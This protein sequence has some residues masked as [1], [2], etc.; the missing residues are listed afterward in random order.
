MKTAGSLGTK[1]IDSEAHTH[2]HKD[3]ERG[4]RQRERAGGGR[5]RER[6]REG[7]GRERD[8]LCA[9]FLYHLSF[10][11][12]FND[13]LVF[14]FPKMYHQINHKQQNITLGNSHSY[15]RWDPESKYV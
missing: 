8:S 10:L 5:E 6:E 11:S 3:R 7:G 2:T 14:C 1:G 15:K 13:Y 12:S 4:Q 9:S